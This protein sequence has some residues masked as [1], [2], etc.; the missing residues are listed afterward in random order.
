MFLNR[1]V[2]IV[3]CV[4]I[5]D[6]RLIQIP[7]ENATDLFSYTQPL[8]KDSNSSR[9]GIEGEWMEKTLLQCENQVC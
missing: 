5:R 6:P 1:S 4:V 3:G 8:D 2:N 9:E 7:D